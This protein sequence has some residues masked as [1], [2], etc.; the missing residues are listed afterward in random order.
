MRDKH[1]CK[2]CECYLCDKNDCCLECQS[3]IDNDYF[4]D[5]CNSKCPHRIENT[6]V[7]N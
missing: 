2:Q 1:K 6:D 4:V 5:T 7:T 3:C